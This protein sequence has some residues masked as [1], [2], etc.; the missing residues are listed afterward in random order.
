[1]TKLAEVVKDQAGLQRLRDETLPV[2]TLYSRPRGR[3]FQTIRLRPAGHDYWPDKVREVFAV[4]I[5]NRARFQ[6]KL[7]SCVFKSVGTL[8]AQDALQAGLSGSGPLKQ[9]KDDLKRRWKGN[10]DWR[11]E[12][13]ELYILTFERVEQ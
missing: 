9:L 6:A 5:R 8:E 12:K 2:I 13:T 1:M 3:C 7:M 11:G 4:K 10:P